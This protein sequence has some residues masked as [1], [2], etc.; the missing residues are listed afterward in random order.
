M[1]FAQRRS[2]A[3][4][5]SAF[6]PDTAH[7]CQPVSYQAGV[8]TWSSYSEFCS[9]VRRVQKHCRQSSVKTESVSTELADCAPDV[10][11]VALQNWWLY[12][13]ECRNGKLYAGI[14]PNVEARFVAHCKGIGAK[15]TRAN[16]P[17]QILAAEPKESR[18]AAAI[19]EYRLKQLSRDEKLRW[20]QRWVWR[21]T[22]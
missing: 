22:S 16:P 5:R 9:I 13:L 3:A 19:A 4:I 14:S 18:S 17:L 2:E 8:L 21:T 20:A 15:F 10:T 6:S 11:A 1:A 12:L 7:D